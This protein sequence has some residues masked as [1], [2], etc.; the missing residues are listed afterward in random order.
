METRSAAR[1]QGAVSAQEQEALLARKPQ[2]GSKL[3]S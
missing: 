3:E 1:P 2:A